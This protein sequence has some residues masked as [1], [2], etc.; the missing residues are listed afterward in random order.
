MTLHACEVYSSLTGH[1]VKSRAH[2]NR[3]EYCYIHDSA[4][5]EFDLVDAADTARPGSHAVLIGNIIVK[6]P[7]CSGN[8]SVIHFGQDGG[9]EHDGTL[10]LRSNTVITPFIA[11]VVELSA[12]GAK[13]ELIGNIVWDGGHRQSGQKLVAVRAGARLENA[14]GRHNRLGGLFQGLDGTALDAATNPIGRF[15]SPLFDD[16]AQHDYRLLPSVAGQLV[17][18]PDA[19]QIALPPLPGAAQTGGDPPLAW[20]YRH[21]ADKQRR[22]T[23][24]VLTLGASGRAQ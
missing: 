1:N 9:R 19:A 18:P 10:H 8:R 17:A 13:A 5:R 11:P 24:A 12:P 6:D 16:P 23:E 21:P 14:S 20:Q 3:I 4:N 15:D 2:F 22:E 7:N